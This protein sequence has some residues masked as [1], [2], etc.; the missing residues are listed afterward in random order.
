MGLKEHLKRMFGEPAAAVGLLQVLL[1]TVV[2]WDQ[3]GLSDEQAG[4]ILGAAAAAAALYQ[5]YITKTVALAVV[6]Q[7][8]NTVVAMFAGFGL[9]LSANQTA[10][11]YGVVA[12]TI[13]A[14][15]RTQTG[16]AAIPGFH[17]EPVVQPVLAVEPAE[18][19]L[20]DDLT[21]ND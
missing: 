18:P 15:L 17:S 13:A 20:P 12:F 11:V 21:V 9:S 5:A 14:W 19:V 1:A 8:F 7:G 4:L 3:I 10:A 16:V 6:A 2:A